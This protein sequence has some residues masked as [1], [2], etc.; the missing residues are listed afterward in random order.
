MEELDKLLLADLEPVIA[1]LP[2]VPSDKVET[3]V[4]QLPEVPTAVRLSSL[5]IASYSKFYRSQRL[6]PK[7]QLQWLLASSLEFIYV[8]VI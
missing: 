2:S 5:L 4:D 1:D 6:R 3:I 7:H 8:N